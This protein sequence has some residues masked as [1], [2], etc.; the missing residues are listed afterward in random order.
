MPRPI[1]TKGKDSGAHWIGGWVRP[2]A[3]VRCGEQKTPAMLGVESRSS[4]PQPTDIKL[5]HHFSSLNLA[6]E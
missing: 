6:V 3:A 1:Y 2:R 5:R 4:N